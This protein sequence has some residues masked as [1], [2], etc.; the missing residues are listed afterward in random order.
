M[1]IVINEKMNAC[2]DCK[3][4]IWVAWWW[5]CVGSSQA[6]TPVHVNKP[7]QLELFPSANQ[8]RSANG[9]SSLVIVL[10]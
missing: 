1:V 6:S 7:N 8:S 3:L 10:L 2:G 4:F 9:N 5:L